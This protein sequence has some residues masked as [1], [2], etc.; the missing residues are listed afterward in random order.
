MKIIEQ[1]IQGKH[2]PETCED[3]LVVTDDFVAVVD[4]ST[5]KS[6]VQLRDDMR[7]GRYCMLEV[8][9]F[10]KTMPA[11][12]SLDDF[13]EG[14]TAHVRRLYG[15]G[16]KI[17]LRHPER[18]LCCSAVIYSRHYNAIWMVG[19][20]QCMTGG[21]VHTNDKPQEEEQGRR[22]A[23][24]FGQACKDHPDML[25]HEHCY[26]GTEIPAIRH[27][28]ARDQI[29]PFIVDT[30]KGEN[31]TYTVIDGFPIY[32]EGIKVVAPDADVHEVVLA[33][34]GYPFLYPTLEATEDALK[35]LLVSDPYCIDRYKSAKGLMLGNH[36]FDDRTYIR[37]TIE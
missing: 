29:V 31:V 12:I 5:S 28:Y 15:G 13:C 16:E 2:S 25:D 7:N 1:F 19:D 30:M 37:F 36:S 4:G 33:S 11:D 26:P 22:R 10:I 9:E 18:R 6:P 27:D 20:C 14:A 21:R 3:G 24:L 17:Y 35:A 34:D 8:S 32:R 23:A